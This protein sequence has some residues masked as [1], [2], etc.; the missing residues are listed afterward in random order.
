TI[1]NYKDKDVNGQLNF[2]GAIQ[3]NIN[4]TTC[5]SITVDENLIHLPFRV[6]KN[7]N[8]QCRIIVTLKWG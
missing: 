7:N 1:F 4:K 2:Y 8:F 3:T 6:T 5:K